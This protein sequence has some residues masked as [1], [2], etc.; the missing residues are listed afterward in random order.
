MYNFELILAAKANKE[1]LN[2]IW[3]TTYFEHQNYVIN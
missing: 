3:N 1:L 2:I